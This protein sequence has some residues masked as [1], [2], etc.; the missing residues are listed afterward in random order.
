MKGS[1]IKQTLRRQRMFVE[2]SKR[3]NLPAKTVRHSSHQD[4]ER[5]RK[6]SLDLWNAFLDRELMKPPL[7]GFKMMLR[8]GR[9]VVPSTFNLY[10]P[11]TSEDINK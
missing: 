8:L 4:R 10:N 6:R 9:S 3:S 1:K 2:P 11:N 5:D 7:S